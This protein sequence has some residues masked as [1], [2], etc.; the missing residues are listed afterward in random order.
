MVAQR[1]SVV[2]SLPP[3]S[4]WAESVTAG[5]SRV[6]VSG[7]IVGVVTS[8]RIT[9]VVVEMA[10]G[11]AAGTG[12]TPPPVAGPGVLAT[13]GPVELAPASAVDR[14]TPSTARMRSGRA[15]PARGTTR[16]ATPS[17]A[18]TL[19]PAAPK[20]IRRRPRRMR[21]ARPRTT[22]SMTSAVR[23]ES[24]GIHG[25]P[26][27]VAEQLAQPGQAS[28]GVGLDRAQRQRETLGDLDVREVG[29]VT[30]HEHVAL[31]P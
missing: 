16:V 4:S 8:G 19:A 18:S 13:A 14:P 27:G 5:T 25:L 24:F 2:P 21:A 9:V 3:T 15:A 1:R 30:E 11:R 22:S 17:N 31:A 20:R 23:H 7:A 28:V 10:R 29:Q 26:G 6:T 12:A